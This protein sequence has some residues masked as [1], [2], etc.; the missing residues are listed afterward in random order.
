MKGRDPPGAKEIPMV[1]PAP[2]CSPRDAFSASDLCYAG[3][4]IKVKRPSWFICVG[5]AAI[6]LAITP[7]LSVSASPEFTG[8]GGVTDSTFLT[9][10][11]TLGDDLFSTT[12]LAT[13][14]T[15]PGT[16]HFGPYPSTSGD[17]GTCGPDW[18]TDTFNRFFAIRQVAPSTFAVYEQFQDGNF[19]ARGTPEASPGNCGSG[20]GGM[21]NA[22]VSGALHGYLAMT[23]S[24]VVTYHPDTA[25]CPAQC[26]STGDFL[27][28]VFTPYTQT[29]DAF[30]F[31]YVAPNQSLALQEWKN[32]S[33]NRGGNSGDIAST[34]TARP[35]Y[36]C[37]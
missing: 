16:M 31:H 32:A 10:I 24:D 1:W 5:A 29:D 21:I 19:V 28:S 37:P 25:S 3:V 2:L 8:P 20:D 34:I 17:S 7:A 11:S 22:N 6:S 15:D 4:C 13:V 26:A 18:A 33:C 12:D 23:I 36:V 9:L 30:F 14:I 35:E 27:G